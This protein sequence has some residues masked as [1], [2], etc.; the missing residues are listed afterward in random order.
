M[1]DLRGGSY[2]ISP[3][4]STIF[5]QISL[6]FPCGF[7][8]SKRPCSVY[9]VCLFVS[10]PCSCC[11]PCLQCPT[12]ISRPSSILPGSTH[13]PSLPR[14]G[15]F[16]TFH[17][18]SVKAAEKWKVESKSPAEFC[19]DV[20]RLLRFLTSAFYLYVLETFLSKNFWTLG[21]LWLSW[22]FMFSTCHLRTRTFSYRISYINTSSVS[23]E[24]DNF[25]L[26]VLS[27]IQVVFLANVFFFF[28]LF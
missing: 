24:I 4:C 10:V 8:S 12:S 6:L 17:L 19:N 23:Q 22:H 16:P 5:G 2:A 9:S 25:D 21:K 3:G 13:M 14:W 15:L 28:F 27:T 20:S 1:N 18:K 7:Y 26:L 11:A